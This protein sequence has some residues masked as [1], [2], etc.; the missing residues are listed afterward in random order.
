[1][2]A[3]RGKISLLNQLLA[4]LLLLRL[5]DLQSFVIFEFQAS[6][7]VNHLFVKFFGHYLLILSFASLFF[8]TRVLNTFNF[9]SSLLIEVVENAW[10][11]SSCS[12]SSFRYLDNQVLGFLTLHFKFKEIH[13]LREQIIFEL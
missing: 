12:S 4:Q 13:F 2:K 9:T 11:A 7:F 1:M 10:A 6:I 8:L 3:V 5:L